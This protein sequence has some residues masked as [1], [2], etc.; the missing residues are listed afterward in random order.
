MKQHA[1]EIINKLEASIIELDKMVIPDTK[2]K[3]CYDV[4]SEF[5]EAVFFSEFQNIISKMIKASDGLR[6]DIGYDYIN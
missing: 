6:D 3:S 5:D 2:C 4:N 1:I